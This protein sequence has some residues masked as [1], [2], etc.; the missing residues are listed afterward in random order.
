MG[1][2]RERKLANLEQRG[3]TPTPHPFNST[4][5]ND[6][7]VDCRPVLPQLL[8]FCLLTQTRG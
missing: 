8:A 7:G 5:T 3:N 1:V 2:Q 4:T 6:I